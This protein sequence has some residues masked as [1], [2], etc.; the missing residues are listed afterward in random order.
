MHAM[1]VT[2]DGYSLRFS[3]RAFVEPSTRSGRRYARVPT[4]PKW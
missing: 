4:A 3:L 2:S 1:A